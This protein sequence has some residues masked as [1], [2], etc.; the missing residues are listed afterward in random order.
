VNNSGRSTR[1]NKQGQ[2]ELKLG[3]QKSTRGQHVKN[4][5]VI[6]RMYVCYSAV[7]LECELGR[8][9]YTVPAL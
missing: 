8:L 4:S 2:N 3:V 7:V 6:S 9:L 1:T 5:R